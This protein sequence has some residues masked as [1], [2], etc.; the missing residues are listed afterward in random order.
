MTGLRVALVGVFACLLWSGHVEASSSQTPA[1]E[2]YC[3]G[4]H[5]DDAQ[6]SDMYPSLLDAVKKRSPSQIVRTILEG[7]FGRGGEAGGHTIAVMPQWD[8]LS[9]AQISDIV[10]ALYHNSGTSN[11]VVTAEDIRRERQVGAWT[12]QEPAL[13]HA[14]F[15]QASNLYF[16][17]CAGCHGVNRQGAAGAALFNWTMAARGTDALKRLCTSVPTG[18]CQ[19]GAPAT[20]L[21][22]MT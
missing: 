9:N 19:T 18:A 2:T 21:V 16:E 12:N 17:R 20:R 22:P 3:S 7:K 8:H 1:Y 11:A 4:C 5:D 10:N 6:G 14:E 15:Q 13:N